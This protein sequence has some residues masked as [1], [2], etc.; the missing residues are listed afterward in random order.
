MEMFKWVKGRDC[1]G[2]LPNLAILHM[3]TWGS[4]SK[5]TIPGEYG[6]R[7]GCG[8]WGFMLETVPVVS[9]VQMA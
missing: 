5:G 2:S 6:Y 8:T 7:L 3:P 9:L 1:V 4:T